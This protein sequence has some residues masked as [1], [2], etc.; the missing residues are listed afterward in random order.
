MGHYAVVV[1]LNISAFLVLSFE[2]SW[3]NFG[4]IY[5]NIISYLVFNKTVKGEREKKIIN[6]VKSVKNKANKGNVGYVKKGSP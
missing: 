4:L 2:E 6:A 1:K 5:L 3:I